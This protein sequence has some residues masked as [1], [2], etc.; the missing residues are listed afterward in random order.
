MKESTPQEAG[1]LRL[2]TSA[3]EKASFDAVGPSVE[4]VALLGDN[5][6]LPAA[7]SLDRE[8]Y[9]AGHLQVAVASRLRAVLAE[10]RLC[11]GDGVEVQRWADAAS[12]HTGRHC[13]FHGRV[14][15]RDRIEFGPGSVFE[16]VSAPV[17]VARGPSEEPF[18]EDARPPVTP[19]SLE[20]GRLP[21]ADMVHPLAQRRTYWR[22]LRSAQAVA[23]Q[24]DLVVQGH[25]ELASG[26]H[27]QGSIKAYQDLHLHGDCE[28]QGHLVARGAIRVGPGAHVRGN[29]MSET[30]IH[31]AAG[32][33]VGTRDQPVS[34]TAPAITMAPG[35]TVHGSMSAYEGGRIG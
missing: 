6:Q 11:C 9:A 1:L 20:R 16:R 13:R 19:S 32:S 10:G 24:G 7:L 22:D 2:A 8:L 17:I 25:V 15:A 31:L 14:S 26:S 35:A 4:A 23:H 5:V 33:V 29:L 28:V 34:I 27:I 3:P 30:C 18:G 12:V 21:T